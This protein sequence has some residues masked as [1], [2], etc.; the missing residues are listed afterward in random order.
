MVLSI[1]SGRLPMA[2]NRR[3][4]AYMASILVCVS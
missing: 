2:L 3:L 4:G 1:Y